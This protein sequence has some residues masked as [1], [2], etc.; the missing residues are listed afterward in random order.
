MM[1]SCLHAFALRFAMDIWLPMGRAPEKKRKN[2]KKKEDM[3]RK[4]KE[5]TEASGEA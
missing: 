3:K 5:R 4:R 1:A 2:K